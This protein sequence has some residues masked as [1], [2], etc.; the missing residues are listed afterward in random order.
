MRTRE[1][2]A[3]TINKPNPTGHWQSAAVHDEAWS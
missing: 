2:Q 3:K 1:N